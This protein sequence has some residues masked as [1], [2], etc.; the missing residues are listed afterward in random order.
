MGQFSATIVGLLIILGAVIML[1]N[2]IRFRKTVRIFNRFASTKTL[3]LSLLGYLH[4]VLMVIFL[5]GY[6]A[7]AYAIVEQVTFFSDLFV[8]AIFLLGSVFVWLGIVIQHHMIHMIRARYEEAWRVKADLEQEQLRLEQINQQLKLEIT[9]RQRAENEL[10]ESE[11]RLKVI[12]DQLPAG[13]LIIDEASKII[14]DVNPAAQKII[15]KPWEEIVGSRCHRFVCPVEEGACPI[16]DIGMDVDKSERM[17]IRAGGEEIPILKTV[18]RI[19]LDGRSHLLESFI[20]LSDKERLEARLQRA[21]KMEA[22]GTLAGGVAHDLNNILSGIT[23][24]P[25]L[26][27]YSLAQESPLRKPL[28]TIKRSGEKA[29]TIVQDMLTLARRGVE[30]KEVLNIGK[31]IEDYFSSPELSRLKSYHPQVTFQSRVAADL[32]NVSGSPVHLF[33]TVMNLVSNGAEAM[34]SGG[35]LTVAVENRHVDLSLSGYDK[36]KEGDYVV[37]S[38]TDTGHGIADEDRERIFEPFYTKKK[39][40]R[41]GTGL[42]MAVVW[43]TVKDH[44]GYIN[45]ESELDRGTTVTVFFPATRQQIAEDQIIDAIKDFKGD[46]ES[47]LIVDDVAEQRQIATEILTVLNYRIHAVPSGEEAVAYLRNNHADLVIMDMIM[48]P[49]LNGLE[50]YQEILKFRAKQRAILV[51][52]YSETDNVRRALELGAGQY[53]KKPYGL[54]AIGMAIRKELDR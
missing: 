19:T 21:Q 34:P 1:A 47:V 51:S 30:I 14:K 36:V 17:L 48:D 29:I 35:S 27:L 28:E 10:R 23:S 50:T 42:G 37:L 2:I 40:G 44:M 22:L 33:K 39:M 38:V 20:D 31:V 26:L 49:G 52:G 41:S 8:G 32:L 45:V 13:V 18:C 9:D 43:G 5:I 11:Q 24:Y 4:Q 46:G 16:I 15:G 54:K 6:L 3:R 12:L 25:E 53:V 7:V